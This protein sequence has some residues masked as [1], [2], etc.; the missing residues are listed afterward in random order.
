MATIGNDDYL[1]TVK[2]QDGYS[3]DGEHTTIVSWLV[4]QLLTQYAIMHYVYVYK[5][6]RPPNF[7]HGLGRTTRKSQVA[8]AISPAIADVN[9][10]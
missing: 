1:C 8:Y 5:S 3:E 10:K 2:Q 9:C 4:P 6:L 7:Y